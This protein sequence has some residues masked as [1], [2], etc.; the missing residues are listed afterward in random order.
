MENIA[1]ILSILSILSII[2]DID[3]LRRFKK[4]NKLTALDKL[5]YHELTTMKYYITQT[6][7]ASKKRPDILK[8]SY[9]EFASNKKQ[10]NIARYIKEFEKNIVKK[11]I[12]LDRL[13]YDDQEIVEHSIDEPKV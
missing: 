11:K 2:I 9:I 6:L 1:N 4:I 13:I 12:P 5:S 8:L 3:F 10:S 7:L